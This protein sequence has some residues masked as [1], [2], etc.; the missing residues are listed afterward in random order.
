MDEA[1]NCLLGM[2]TQTELDYLFQTVSLLKR[3]S[4]WMQLCVYHWGM[5]LVLWLYKQH[6]FAYKKVEP[7]L[8][9]AKEKQ[10]NMGITWAT[11]EEKI[12]MC[13]V[14]QTLTSATSGRPRDWKESW[15]LQSKR[16]GPSNAV[17]LEGPV[18]VRMV[19]R[20][21]SGETMLAGGMRGA[22]GN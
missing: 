7:V 13:S 16:L 6:F 8:K 18:G 3:L 11:N 1:I 2:I 9:P 20:P 12:R 19:R 10:T 4:C 21:L 14:Q 22:G 15:E 5:Q 17:P